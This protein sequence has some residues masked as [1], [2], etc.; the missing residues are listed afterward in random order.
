M[1]RTIDEARLGEFMG[2]MAGYMTGGG[3]V[4]WGVAGATSWA[5][6]R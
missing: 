2:Q 3:A 5:S 4:L 6:A 1:A